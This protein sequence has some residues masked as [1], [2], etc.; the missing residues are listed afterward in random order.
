MSGIAA[1]TV[2]R[3]AARPR[4]ECDMDAFQSRGG[5]GADALSPVPLFSYGWLL[6]WQVRMG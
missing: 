4:R 6:E 2:K 1:S 5:T 3:V